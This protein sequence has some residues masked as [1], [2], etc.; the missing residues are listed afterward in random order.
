MAKFRWQTQN[1]VAALQPLGFPITIGPPG[2]D[3]DTSKLFVKVGKG[4][5]G[6]GFYIAGWTPGNPLQRSDWDDHHVAAISLGDGLDS[7]GGLTSNDPA[8]IQA[9]AD[10]RIILVGLL[11][12]TE[13]HI[14]NHYDEIF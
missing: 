1:L 10:I 6:T 8:M 2:G 14:I 3:Y 13:T 11:E 9:Y 5:F 4:K 7:R 12:D